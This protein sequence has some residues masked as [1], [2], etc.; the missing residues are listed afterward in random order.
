MA[1]PQVFQGTLNLLLGNVIYASYPSLNVTSPYLGT[2]GIQ[3]S[4]DGDTSLLLPTMTGAVTSPRPYIFANVDMHILRSQALGNAYKTQIETNTTLGSVSV[5]TDST[6]LSSFQLDNTVLLS[7]SQ[8][9]FDG[10][11]PEMLIR[12]RGVYSVNSALFNAA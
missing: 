9:N 1:N 4:F 2:G 12:L 5:Y 8:L 3:I 7:L 6:T 11:S 10:A